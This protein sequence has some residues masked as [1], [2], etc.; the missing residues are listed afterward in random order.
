MCFRLCFPISLPSCKK[1]FLYPF[2]PPNRAD[3]VAIQH[4]EAET[5]LQIC[6]KAVI[7]ETPNDLIQMASICWSGTEMWSY[8]AQQQFQ[9]CMIL[10]LMAPFFGNFNSTSWSWHLVCVR[11]FFRRGVVPLCLFQLSLLSVILLIWFLFVSPKF[12]LSCWK[13]MTETAFFEL[14]IFYS[15]VP[16]TG[17]FTRPKIARAI[18][19]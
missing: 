3:R 8:S 6:K 7:R 17:Y 13:L 10:H 14:R 9:P 2:L 16:N 11:T 4:F 5:V 15:R 18:S 1:N 19:W 12:P